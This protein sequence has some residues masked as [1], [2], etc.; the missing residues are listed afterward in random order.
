MYIGEEDKVRLQ[1]NARAREA[2]GWQHSR[3]RGH[4]EPGTPRNVD[5]LAKHRR[6]LGIRPAIPHEVPDGAHIGEVF[7]VELDIVD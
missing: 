3:L 1:K 4:A 6:F 5:F 2:S 7:V